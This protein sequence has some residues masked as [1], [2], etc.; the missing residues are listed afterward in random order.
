MLKEEA[1][2]LW[3]QALESGRYEQGF[4]I[5]NRNNRQ[6]PLG[7][8][9]ILYQ[10]EVGGLAVRDDGD[11]YAVLYDELGASPPLR[12]LEWLGL[13]DQDVVRFMHLNDEELKSFPEIALAI[14]QIT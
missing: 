14:R 12:V 3:A 1:R 6:C 13:S 2:E 8:A 10:E 4:R 5:L 11:G 7:V 9:C